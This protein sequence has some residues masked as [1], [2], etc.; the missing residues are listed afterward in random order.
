L[1]HE[2]CAIVVIFADAKTAKIAIELYLYENV[3]SLVQEHKPT[4]CMLQVSTM[5]C[6]E[7]NAALQ[8]EIL[9]K[10][11]IVKQKIFERLHQGQLDGDLSP[12]A[13]IQQ[14]TDYYAT[15]IQGLSLQARDGATLEQLNQVVSMAMLVWDIQHQSS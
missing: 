3:K 5:N 11:L 12:Q 4:G 15:V 2:A 13:N 7:Q 6:S 10:R 1:E 8:N 14:L 9:E